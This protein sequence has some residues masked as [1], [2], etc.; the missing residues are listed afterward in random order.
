MFL[1]SVPGWQ[2]SY[3][4]PAQPVGRGHCC[5]HTV[6]IARGEILNDKK[7]FNPFL[8]KAEMER[9]RNFENLRAVYVWRHDISNSFCKNVIKTVTVRASVVNCTFL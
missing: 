3:T 6:S 4:R 7:C 2:R 5:P 8:G 9:R 1:P